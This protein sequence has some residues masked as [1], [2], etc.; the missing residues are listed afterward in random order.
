[1]RF[2]SPLDE[3]FVSAFARLMP[4]KASAKASSMEMRTRVLLAVKAIL[5]CIGPPLFSSRLTRKIG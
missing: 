3:Y 4:V 1:M 5:I 2:K